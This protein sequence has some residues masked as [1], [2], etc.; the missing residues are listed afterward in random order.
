MIISICFRVNSKTAIKFRVWA[1]KLIKEYIVKAFNL[2]L[3][4][5]VIMTQEEMIKNE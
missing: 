5:L 2:N 3:E 1:N 4:C